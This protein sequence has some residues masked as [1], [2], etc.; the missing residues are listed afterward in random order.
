MTALQLARMSKT[1][2]LQAMEALWSDLSGD[3]DAFE[4]PAWH[5][6]ALAEAEG[7]YKAGKAHFVDLATAKKQLAKRRK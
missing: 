6:K 3:A 1:Q 2:K 4:S 5:A 7:Q